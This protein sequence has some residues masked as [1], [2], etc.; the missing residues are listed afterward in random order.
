M[1]RPRHLAKALAELVLRPAIKLARRDDLAARLHQSVERQELRRVARCH[2]QR[3]LPA[4]QRR[5][6]AL[7]RPVGRVSDPGLVIS[8]Y[9]E[10]ETSQGMVDAVDALS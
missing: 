6:F 1:R 5:D 4:F 8:E 9:F 2:R 3:G 10:I 7:E